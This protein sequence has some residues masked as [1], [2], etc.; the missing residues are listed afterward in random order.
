[1][2]AGVVLT[3]LLVAHVRVFCTYVYWASVVTFPS[4]SFHFSPLFALHQILFKVFRFDVFMFSVE[5][6]RQQF[7]C[8]ATWLGRVVRF[9]F[10]HMDLL[11]SKG[12]LRKK[13]TSSG[14]NPANPPGVSLNR[15]ELKKQMRYFFSRKDFLRLA[16]NVLGIFLA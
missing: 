16:K 5:E 13:H 10:H 12:I 1:M 4:H 6:T 15:L 14:T 8:V 3:D 9:C 2:M 7:A 11:L